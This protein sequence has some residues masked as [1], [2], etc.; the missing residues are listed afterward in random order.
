MGGYLCHPPVGG[1]G[2]LIV[3]LLPFSVYPRSVYA[4]LEFVLWLYPGRGGWGGRG[5]VGLGDVGGG[6]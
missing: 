6:V 4:F 1:N 3:G 2:G 5:I